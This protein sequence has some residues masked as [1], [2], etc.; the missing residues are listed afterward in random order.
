MSENKKRIIGSMIIIVG[1][2]SVIAGGMHYRNSD[3]GEES[4]QYSDS[5]ENYKF[6]VCVVAHGMPGDWNEQVRRFVDKVD[7][8]VLSL[9]HI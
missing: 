8:P 1:L 6:G 5:D 2:L 9:I 4:E 7:L 3:N